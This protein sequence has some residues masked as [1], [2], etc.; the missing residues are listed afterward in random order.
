MRPWP[1]ERAPL[2]P[3]PVGEQ[4]E[5][6]ADDCEDETGAAEPEDAR[7]NSADERAGDPF[8]DEDDYVGEEDEDD[9]FARFFD[10]FERVFGESG[11]EDEDEFGGAVFSPK[12][13]NA[14]VKELYRALVRRLHP[15][16]R[17]EM[18][19]QQREWWHQAQEAYQNEDAEQLEVLQ[20]CPTR[21]KNGLQV[22][23]LSRQSASGDVGG[24][25]AV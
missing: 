22:A 6:R 24:H 1:G 18:S 19:P 12:R 4:N 15:D 11:S 2:H 3:P 17:G 13:T 14:R 9:P 23:L 5:H 8:E 10:E 25:L 16:A 21:F 7:D 20:V